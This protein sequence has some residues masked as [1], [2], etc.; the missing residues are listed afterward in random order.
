MTATPS[1]SHGASELTL[2][3]ICVTPRDAN[4]GVRWPPEEG[5]TGLAMLSI[6]LLV[7][8]GHG[9]PSLSAVQYE[10]CVPS[11]PFVDLNVL[12]PS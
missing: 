6:S 9:N 1:Q 11:G 10:L 8:A 4:T 12:E 5:T 7:H 3:G 2:H